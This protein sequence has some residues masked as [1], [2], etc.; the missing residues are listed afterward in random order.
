MGRVCHAHSGIVMARAG[1]YDFHE[2]LLIPPG[3][4]WH[5]DVL[6]LS[7]FHNPCP[8]Q[9]IRCSAHVSCLLESNAWTLESSE[10]GT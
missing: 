6:Q 3:S 7:A 2:A 10:V 1:T 8:F 4:H 5:A 9:M